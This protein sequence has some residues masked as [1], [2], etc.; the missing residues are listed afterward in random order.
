MQKTPLQH[1]LEDFTLP[2]TFRWT[3][4]DSRKRDMGQIWR[5]LLDFP[6]K[7]DGV[8]GLR[9]HTHSMDYPDSGNFGLDPECV[10]L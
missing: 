4:P 8:H 2:H 10:D 3:P 5:T 7:N 9:R 6:P 1:L